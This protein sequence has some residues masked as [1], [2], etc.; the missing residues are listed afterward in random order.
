MNKLLFAVL[1]TFSATLTAAPF[2]QGYPDSGDEV[3]STTDT[4][5]WN[6]DSGFY[7]RSDVSSGDTFGLYSLNTAGSVVSTLAIFTD[8]DTVGDSSNVVFDGTD[9]LTKYGSISLI[10]N[11]FGFYYTDQNAVYYSQTSLNGGADKFSFHPVDDRF[12]DEDLFVVYGD[13][14]AISVNDVAVSHVPVP[15]AV[16]L[17][18]S[19]LIGLA[20]FRK[21]PV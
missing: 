21:R 2:Y 11:L 9:V 10:D 15:A 7:L 12:V 20:A 3:W 6:D 13:D 18:G 17:F 5:G 4:D 16:W 8:T 19:G 14:F 1:L